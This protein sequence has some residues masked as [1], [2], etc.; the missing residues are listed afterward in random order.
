MH[1][2]SVVVFFA[3]VST[4]TSAAIS[5]HE[6]KG[7]INFAPLARGPRK[8]GGVAAIDGD[9]YVLGGHSTAT[10]HG[11]EV[12]NWV[13]VFN[14][15]KNSWRNASNLPEPLT[16]LNAIGLNGRLYVL[17]AMDVALPFWNGT[18]K[19]WEYDPITDKWSD[20]PPLPDVARGASAVA[21]YENTIYVVGGSTT[22]SL[23]GD[24]AVSTAAVSAFN[25]ETREWTILP[26]LP[27]AR[28]HFGGA[29]IDGILYVSGGRRNGA[30]HVFDNTYALDLKAKTP[31]WVTKA[32]MPT[33][34]GGQLTSAVGNI[35][36]TFGGEST[37]AVSGDALGIYNQTEAYDTANDAW[38][39]LE[40]MPLPRHGTGAVAVGNCNFIP[41]GGLTGDLIVSTP[42]DANTAFCV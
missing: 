14:V 31:V 5:L 23:T 20:L 29:A 33:P 2:L 9:I 16:H 28:D 41:G 42:T 4:V 6:C 15:G 13:E 19:S 24:G 7:W 27:E 1:Y 34:R 8:E 37:A 18:A 39:K 25:T 26:D 32:K 30:E 21:S 11:V 10:A 12:L 40:P 3:G 22:L 35:I 38:H 17:G 36:Y